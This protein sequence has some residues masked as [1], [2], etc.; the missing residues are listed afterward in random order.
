MSYALSLENVQAATEAQ[1]ILLTGLVRKILTSNQSDLE[2][3]LSSHLLD[4]DKANYQSA[5]AKEAI[6]ESFQNWGK[7]TKLEVRPF[8]VPEIKKG[9]GAKPL[10]RYMDSAVIILPETK[11]KRKE[12]VEKLNQA[13]TK[14]GFQILGIQE[15]LG[16]KTWSAISNKGTAYG[17]VH[18][19]GEPEGHY[20]VKITDP[21][22]LPE[23]I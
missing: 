4:T 15:D 3:E 16:G 9:P 20:L 12:L 13:F 6:W 18:V 17:F 10:K 22:E 1:N 21:A 8:L 5:K 11:A 19:D 23:T 7:K 2:K 14:N